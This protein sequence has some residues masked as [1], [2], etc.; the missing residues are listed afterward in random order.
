MI[1]LPNYDTPPLAPSL[2]STLLF[3]DGNGNMTSKD[4]SGNVKTYTPQSSINQNMIY[5]VRYDKVLDTIT[6]GIVVSGAFIATDYSNFPIQELCGRGLL[7]TT[8]V[9]TKLNKYNSNKFEDGSTATLNGSAGQVMVRIPRFYQVIKTVGDYQYFLISLQSFTFDS[10]IAW[11]PLAFGDSAYKYIG[12]F[13]S[14]ALTDSLTASAVSAVIDTSAYSTNIYPNPFA[15]RTRAQFRTQQQSGFF[16]YSWGLY[17]IVRVLF[18][19]KYKTWNSQAVLPGYT[20]GGTFD[21]AKVTKA[22]ATLGLGDFD[23]S[24]WDSVNLRYKANSFLGIENFYGNVYNLLDGI[25]ID[26]TAGLCTVYTCNTPTNF[27]DDTTTNYVATGHSPAFG[28]VSD[29]YKYILGSGKD[30]PFYP[31]VLGSGATS[32]TY[33]TDYFYNTAGV[34]GVLSCGGNLAHG[35]LAGLA[36]LNE[37]SAS[38]YAYSDLSAR[39]AA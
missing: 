10:T 18:L 24:I 21:Y 11:I 4:S 30:C 36:Y 27:A 38:S 22:G 31:S 19:T 35:A 34:W 6:P 1:D 32:A 14:V 29:C 17:E 13:Q 25:N 2:G 7:T 28:A 15:N 8:G 16:Q 23:G 33:Q 12:A 37:Y 39:S 9:W 3:I 26:N 20:E 5:G